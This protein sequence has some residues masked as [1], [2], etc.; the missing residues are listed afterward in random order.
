MYTLGSWQEVG[1]LEVEAL[2]GTQGLFI[3][4]GITFFVFVGVFYFAGHEKYGGWDNHPMTEPRLADIRCIHRRSG[5]THNLE[6]H[7]SNGRIRY[8]W[9][10]HDRRL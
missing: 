6:H 1:W 5:G 10:G 9:L 4:V 3:W 8:P 2:E 7:P